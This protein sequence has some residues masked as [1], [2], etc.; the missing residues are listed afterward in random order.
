MTAYN[1]SNRVFAAFSALAISALFMATA[2]VP[3]T[4]TGILA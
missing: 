3:A 4:P 2:I 1:F